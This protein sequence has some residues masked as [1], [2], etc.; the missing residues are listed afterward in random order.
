MKV[1]III[2][3]LRMR[4]KLNLELIEEHHYGESCGIA[5]VRPFQTNG[6]KLGETMY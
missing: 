1:V 2:I 3:D 6:S 5:T 4:T